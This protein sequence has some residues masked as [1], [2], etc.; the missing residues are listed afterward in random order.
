MPSSGYR[1]A[2]PT[3]QLEG[4]LPGECS[5]VVLSDNTKVQ[6]EDTQTICD[7]TP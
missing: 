7:R 1:Y 3:G 2:L 6:K 4:L 5:G